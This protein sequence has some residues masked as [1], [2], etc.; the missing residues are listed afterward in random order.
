MSWACIGTSSFLSASDP[1]Q[2]CLVAPILHP[3]QPTCFHYFFLC[4]Y[5]PR[6][7]YDI[8]FPPRLTQGRPPPKKIDVT[9]QHISIKKGLTIY[10]PEI[11]QTKIR[12][13]EAYRQD[14]PA[15]YRDPHEIKVA[16]HWLIAGR[17][18]GNLG[19]SLEIRHLV[20]QSTLPYFN[21][22]E[23]KRI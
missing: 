4:H 17:S 15:R 6:Y 18:P 20:H 1:I 13:R 3:C 14:R 8:Y 2:L 21:A 19:Q 12:N 23:P 7:L 22:S 10:A 11:S 9:V 5:I 16:D